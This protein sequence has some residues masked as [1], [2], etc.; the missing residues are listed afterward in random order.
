MVVISPWQ[1]SIKISLKCRE[2]VNAEFITLKATH[3]TDLIQDHY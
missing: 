3:K 1:A 2:A